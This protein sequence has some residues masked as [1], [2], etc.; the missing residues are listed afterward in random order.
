MTIVEFAA[1]AVALAALSLLA[2]TTLAVYRNIRNSRVLSC[3]QARQ[4]SQL[5]KKRLDLIELKNRKRLMEETVRDGT[6]AV[7]AI[8]RTI[9]GVTFD[10]VDR[11]SSSEDF[12]VRARK[13]RTTH[14]E[15]TKTFYKALRTTNR[16][17]HA[18]T[19]MVMIDKQGQ[20]KD[21]SDKNK[22]SGEDKD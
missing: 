4:A 6:T 2:L 20:G 3:A 12:K 19:D 10:L 21:N 11:Y 5:Q 13:A 17:L 18:F 22:P 8:H 15:T 14:D 16:A 9:T 7:E 1:L